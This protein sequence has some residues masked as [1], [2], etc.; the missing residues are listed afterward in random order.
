MVMDAWNTIWVWVGKN[1]SKLE[2][3]KVFERID[4]Y[5]K[6]LT[7]GRTTDKI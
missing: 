1:S 5:I 6:A 3:R 2:Q 4:T 7:D